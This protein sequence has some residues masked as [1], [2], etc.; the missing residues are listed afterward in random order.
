[1]YR[2]LTVGEKAAMGKWPDCLKIQ[3]NLGMKRMPTPICPVTKHCRL[4]A[5]ARR[6]APSR[7]IVHP[8][9]MHWIYSGTFLRIDSLTNFLK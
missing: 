8:G 3:R 6:A 4:I 5:A 1:M 7:Y 9:H 2:I